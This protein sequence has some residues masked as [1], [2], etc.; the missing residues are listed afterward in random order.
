MPPRIARLVR[1]PDWVLEQTLSLLRSAPYR[2]SPTR[3]AAEHEVW[4]RHLDEAVAEVLDVPLPH[5]RSLVDEARRARPPG[6]GASPM[7]ARDE[8]RTLLWI[9]VI[10]ERPGHVVET[11]VARGVTSLAVLGALEENAEGMLH[12]IDLPLPG[13]DRSDIGSLVPSELRHRWDLRVGASRRLLRPLLAS[14]GAIDLF[15]AD[16]D[17][18]HAAQAAEYR[19][20]WGA[21][22]PGGILVSDDVRSLAL[23]R[24]ASDL[25]VRPIIVPPDELTNPVGI[26]RKPG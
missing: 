23:V 13:T 7:D 17:H 20:A 24:F 25:G 10:A 8:L 14:V 22:R 19:A 12:S 18:R 5:A 1:R 11:G 3:L 2:V 9:L 6:T 26:L 4:A 16:G 15:V 21:L